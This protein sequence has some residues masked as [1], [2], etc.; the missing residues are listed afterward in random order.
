M[1]QPGRVPARRTPASL[2]TRGPSPSPIQKT[3]QRPTATRPYGE[4]CISACEARDL[5]NLTLA[6][7]IRLRDSSS[8]CGRPPGPCSRHDFSP[9]GFPLTYPPTCTTHD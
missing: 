9:A 3:V 1:K 2:L 6:D 5:H 4:D 7:L 8:S